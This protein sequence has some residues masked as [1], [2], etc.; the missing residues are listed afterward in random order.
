MP[1]KYS[2]AIVLNASDLD[3]VAAEYVIPGL[4][5]NPLLCCAG[6]SFAPHFY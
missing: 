1:G 4:T 3:E 2:D 6:A 5:R